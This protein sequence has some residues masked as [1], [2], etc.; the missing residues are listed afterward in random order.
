MSPITLFSAADIVYNQT[1][2]KQSKSRLD[3]QKW[4]LW[5]ASLTQQPEDVTGITSA[6]ALSASA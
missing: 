5:L 4:E 1:A 6:W 3:D 2:T